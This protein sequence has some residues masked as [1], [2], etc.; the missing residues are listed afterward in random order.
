MV[1]NCIQYVVIFVEPITVNHING[2]V[3]S[4]NQEDCS[5]NHE[6]LACT[7]CADQYMAA[8]NTGRVTKDPDWSDPSGPLEPSDLVEWKKSRNSHGKLYYVDEA[9]NIYIYIFAIINLLELHDSDLVQ[10]KLHGWWT[11]HRFPRTMCETHPL[12]WLWCGSIITT[13]TN[14]RN[15]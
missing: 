10:S 1:S 13:S 8:I 7:D 12:G 15:P 14:D 5:P 6:R 4:M 2:V 9:Y 3:L 11:K